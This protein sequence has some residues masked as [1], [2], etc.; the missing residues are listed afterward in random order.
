[1]KTYH[2]RVSQGEDG[3]LVAQALNLR[4]AITQGRDLDE[5]AF[6]IRDAVELLTQTR[7]FGLVLR[8]D[9]KLRPGPRNTRTSVERR[10]VDFVR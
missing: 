3:W 5:I 1:M 8:L 6:M 9:P 10:L 2:I 4:G 7:N